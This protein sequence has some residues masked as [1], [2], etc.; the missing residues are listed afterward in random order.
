LV[1]RIQYCYKLGI[2]SR[3]QQKIQYDG[4]FVF[5]AT[6]S[7]YRSTTLLAVPPAERL[8]LASNIAC[9][10]SVTIKFASSC[11]PLPP[12]MIFIIRRPMTLLDSNAKNTVE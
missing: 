10:F 9:T 3:V 5:A 12:D 7:R 2:S 11:A 4:R 6:C 8:A 1:Q